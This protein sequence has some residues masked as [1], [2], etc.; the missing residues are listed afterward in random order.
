VVA[1][2][3]IGG[4]FLLGM[5]AATGYAARTLPAGAR[6]PLNAGVPEHSVWLSKPAGLAAWLGAGVAAFAVLAALTLNSLSAN[7]ADSMRVAL[8]PSVMLVLLAAETAAVIVARRCATSPEHAPPEHAP[9]DHAP[10]EHAPPDHAQPRDAPP[11][12]ESAIGP[13]TVTP[14]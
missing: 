2:L 1:A 8:L 14:D 12:Q 9:P 6:V 4:V 7:W 13:E 10:P 11:L 3:V 5:V